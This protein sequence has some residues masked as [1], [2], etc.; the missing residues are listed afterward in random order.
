MHRRAVPPA[1][2]STPLGSSLPHPV[3]RQ[4]GSFAIMTPALFIL[5]LVF[6]GLALDLARMYNRK[7]ELQTA[8]DEIALAAA[9]KLNGTAAGI[10]D[11]EAAAKATA[12]DILYDYRHTAI[13]WSSDAIG[14]GASPYATTWNDTSSATSQAQKLFYVKVDTSRLA[15]EIGALDT[16][17]M[18]VVSASNNTVNVASRAVAGRSSIGVTPIGICAMSSSAGSARGTELVQYGFRRGVSYD[19]MQLNPDTTTNGANPVRFLVNPIAPPGATGTSII[20]KPDVFQPFMCTGS[21]AMPSISGGSVT[22]EPLDSAQPLLSMY[23]QLN[24]RFGTSPAPCTSLTAPPDTNVKSYILSTLTWMNTT[25]TK[26][27]AEKDTTGNKIRTVADLDTPP[28]TTTAGQFGPLWISAKAVP[29]SAYQDG[30][31]EPAAGY[32]TF[33]PTDTNWATLYTPGGQKFKGSYPSPTPY[34]NQTVAGAKGVKNRRVLNIPLL[35]CPASGSPAKANVLAIGK[36][37]MTV[38][39]TDKELYAEF[40]GLAQE[41][42]LSGQVELYQ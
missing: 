21:M 13:T 39:A 32:A 31:A 5:M 4:R 29:Y 24:S 12:E 3:S 34:T 6:W 36:F 7:A 28:P 17:F 40:V 30:V 35:Q 9:A 18:R 26:Q 1:A 20:G 41:K 27:S 38:P 42:S 37:F 19:L 33:A 16:F 23:P 2:E 25:P 11:A 10:T 22:V 8:A 14:F 15:Q